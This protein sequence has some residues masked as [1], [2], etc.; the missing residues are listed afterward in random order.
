MAAALPGR[1][2]PPG[3]QPWPVVRSRSRRGGAGGIAHTQ[4]DVR[5]LGPR[6]VL[7]VR[8]R[9]WCRWGQ[10][11]SCVQDRARGRAARRLVA[12]GRRVDAMEVR[13]LQRMVAAVG[14]VDR[15]FRAGFLLWVQLLLQRDGAQCAGW[16]RSS[17]GAACGPV[18]LPCPELAG[19]RLSAQAVR[20]WVRPGLPRFPLAVLRRAS[21]SGAGPLFSF[22]QAGARTAPPPTQ[23]RGRGHL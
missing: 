19:R 18:R 10:D 12:D 13:E 5:R 8:A 23:K 7:Q 14:L 20:L 15:S 11:G 3:G 4:F 22:T 1:A 6:Q 17:P 16:L 9:W 2:G 21:D